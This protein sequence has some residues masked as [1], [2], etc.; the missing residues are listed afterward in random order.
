ME[1]FWMKI[2][3]KPDTPVKSEVE[4]DVK[5][6]PEYDFIVE[7][8]DQPDNVTVS[9][10][11]TEV[12]IKNEADAGIKN[13]PEADIEIKMELEADQEFSVGTK[14]NDFKVRMLIIILLWLRNIKIC[15]IACL[16]AA[17]AYIKITFL[18]LIVN[19]LKCKSSPYSESC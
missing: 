2:P 11:E 4:F 16:L 1:G 19:G 7:N 17:W 18:C 8:L 6:E 3:P 10:L 12:Q 14:L 9:E 13:E 5:S 15:C